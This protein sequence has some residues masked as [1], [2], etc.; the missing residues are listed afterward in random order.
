MRNRIGTVLCGLFE[1]L[2]WSLIMRI[3]TEKE[4][5]R[6]EKLL[7]MKEMGYT[8]ESNSRV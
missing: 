4:R 1:V 5:E 3:D 7:V 2:D 8:A 6:E